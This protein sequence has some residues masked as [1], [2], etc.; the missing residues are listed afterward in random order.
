LRQGSEILVTT[1]KGGRIGGQVLVDGKKQVGWVKLSDV[2]VRP[3]PDGD[4]DQKPRNSIVAG[5]WRLQVVSFTTQA[6]YDID[7]GRYGTKK[8]QHQI[9]APSGNVVAL[10]RIRCQ[11][12]RAYS[13]AEKL[14]IAASGKGANVEEWL[15]MWEE[16]FDRSPFLSTRS[17]VLCYIGEASLEKKFIV[18]SCQWLKKERNLVDT[19]FWAAKEVYAL[20]SEG[21]DEVEATLVFLYNPSDNHPILL[22]WPALEGS[23]T[24]GVRISVQ[25]D[26]KVTFEYGTA[27]EMHKYIPKEFR[28]R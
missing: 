13:E 17:F 19:R 14:K 16:W 28:R 18:S 12:L 1:I 10:I 2:S 3:R 27:K 6:T 22:F 21:E 23:E 5:P 24:V 4:A 20:A 11:Q 25:K 7:A 9:A 8:L 15:K 26:A